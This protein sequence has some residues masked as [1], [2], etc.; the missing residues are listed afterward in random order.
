MKNAVTELA[1]E[2]SV[3]Q[4]FG[5]RPLLETLGL[6]RDHDL[7]LEDLR[8]R[9]VVLHAFQMLCPGCVSHGIPQAQRIEKFFSRQDV[10]VVGL[11]TVFEHHAA[12]TPV[13][14][15]AFLHEYRVTFPVGV[16]EPGSGTDIPK[17][18]HAYGMRGTPS[19]LLIDRAGVVRAHSFG[20]PEDL[21]VG[22][23]IAALVGE[24]PVSSEVDPA[25]PEGCNEDGCAV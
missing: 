25:A 20:R 13:S 7:A 12:M 23:S 8:G 6:E 10:V 24:D 3:Q 11:H 5:A 17:T 4:W 22:A 21:S 19:L 18:M 16:D 2:W 15:K 14:L 1:P 9:V